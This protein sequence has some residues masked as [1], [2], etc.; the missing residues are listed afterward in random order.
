FKPRLMKMAKEI[1]GQEATS[2]AADGDSVAASGPIAAST[3]PH[4]AAA[5]ASVAA[6]FTPISVDDVRG[7]VLSKQLD[8][9]ESDDP[10]TLITALV[11]SMNAAEL[12]DTIQSFGG[13]CDANADLSAL[14]KQFRSMVDV[15]AA[16]ASAA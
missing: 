12:K 2:S 8:T 15:P 9:G 7:L 6:P 10:H 5:A 11:N 3:P 1:V 13:R 4:T 16:A 14:R